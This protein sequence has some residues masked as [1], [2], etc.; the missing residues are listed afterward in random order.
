MKPQLHRL[1]HRSLDKVQLR[2]AAILRGIPAL[3]DPCPACDVAELDVEHEP[4][5]LGEPN[6]LELKCRHL[7][8]SEGRSARVAPRRW[9]W[10]RR[11]GHV[12]E[13]NVAVDRHRRSDAD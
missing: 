13:L 9:G 2:E 10:G 12:A 6:V 3:A 1:V 4:H 5:R 7:T 11:A 8:R